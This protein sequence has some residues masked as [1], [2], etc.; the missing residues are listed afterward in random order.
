MFRHPIPGGIHPNIL[1]NI[2][3]VPDFTPRPMIN[4]EKDLNAFT[5]D[6]RSS[7]WLF[8][9]EL[10]L[11]N[12]SQMLIDGPEKIAVKGSGAGMTTLEGLSFQDE[13]T[14]RRV[15]NTFILPYCTSQTRVD[16]N[17]ICFE[18]Y[19][20]VQRSDEEQVFARVHVVAPPA[21]RYTVVSIFKRPRECS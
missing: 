6:V 18:D 8:L 3:Y 16:E 14:L 12:A 15:L 7:I 2:D 9:E 13:Q 5:G 1:R 10:F 17:N 11:T 19:L 4:V 21:S 20:S